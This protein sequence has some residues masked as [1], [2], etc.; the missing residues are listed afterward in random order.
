MIMTYKTINPRKVEYMGFDFEARYIS[1]V[2]EAYQ[3][4]YVIPY[5]CQVVYFVDKKGDT[6]R[7]YSLAPMDDLMVKM[8]TRDGSTILGIEM[9]SEQCFG[10]EDFIIRDAKETAKLLHEWGYV[11]YHPVEKERG[12]A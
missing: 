12:D 1:A 9:N 5:A 2:A 6:H 3:E 4:E 8:F 10:I 7:F 11:T